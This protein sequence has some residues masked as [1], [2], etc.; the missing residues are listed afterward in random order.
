MRRKVRWGSDT[1]VADLT[2][3]YLVGHSSLTH[4]PC[5]CRP[6][7]MLQPAIS[8]EPAQLPAAFRAAAEVVRSHVDYHVYTLFPYA[9]RCSTN[10]YWR[11]PTYAAPPI[12]SPRRV[13]APCK[14][15][16]QLM[17]QRIFYIGAAV[18]KNFSTGYLAV[19]A[20]SYYDHQRKRV[21]AENAEK[22][23]SIK[24]DLLRGLKWQQLQEDLT[25][26]SLV[27]EAQHGASTVYSSGARRT[28]R[29]RKNVRPSSRRI[30][31]RPREGRAA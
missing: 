18:R 24:E 14:P 9:K 29:G 7:A 25:T 16:V 10:A 30:N 11:L 5:P 20:L 12:D 8:V 15:G 3:W 2:L 6:C 28:L 22:G 19:L 21:L 1:A 17:V 27:K 31:V 26:C 23:E 4:Y 13:E